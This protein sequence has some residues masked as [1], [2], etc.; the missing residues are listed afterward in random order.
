MF[1]SLDFIEQAIRI[2]G[3]G[4]DV[5]GVLIIVGGLVWSVGMFL[6]RQRRH[7]DIDHYQP[8]KTRIGRFLILRLE[9]L[10]A[11]DIIKTV[12]LTQHSPVLG[13]WL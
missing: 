4:V 7:P 1:E 9:V 6:H 2:V 12:T 13:S 5:F 10:L 3:T 8:F 11:A